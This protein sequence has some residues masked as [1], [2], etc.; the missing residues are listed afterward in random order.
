MRAMK[1]RT[2]TASSKEYRDT[3][4][5]PA[6]EWDAVSTLDLYGKAHPDLK[7]QNGIRFP[8]QGPLGNY[9]PE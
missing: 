5:V 2:T 3:G 9:I 8:K 1:P 4:S 6:L 7:A